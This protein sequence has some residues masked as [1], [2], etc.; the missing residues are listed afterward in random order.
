MA[1]DSRAA[2]RCAGTSRARPFSRSTALL[3]C[4]PREAGLPQYPGASAPCSPN[5]EDAR[6][7]EG[8]RSS[9]PPAGKPELLAVSSLWGLQ[10]LGGRN[11]AERWR[12]L[13]AH[14]PARPQS[15]V[16][17]A[18]LDCA[19]VEAQAWGAWQPQAS[20]LWS[21]GERGR[22]AVAREGWGRRGGRVRAGRPARPPSVSRAPP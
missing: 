10:P 15:S 5:V 21:A 2:W 7:E 3:I 13:Q 22:A 4:V 16:P 12:G 20:E 11:K 19:L 1:A 17:V 18:S 8:E 9:G 6:L 14:F